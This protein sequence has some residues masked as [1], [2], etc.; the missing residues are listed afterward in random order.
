MKYFVIGDLQAK[1]ENLHHVESVCLEAETQEHEYVI[2]L[3]DMLEHRGRIEAEVLNFLY[4]YFKRSRK[5][6]FILC[7]NH[8]LVSVH[9]E[10]TALEPLKALKNVWVIDTPTFLPNP[11]T[12]CI[13]VPYYR[14]P[15]KFLH[16]ISFPGIKAV[17]CHQGIKEFTMGSGY[18]EDEAV[19]MDDVKQF[20][21]VVAGHYH[22]PMER[23]NV[24]YLGSPFSHS[25]GESNERKRYGIFDSDSLQFTYVPSNFPAHTTIEIELPMQEPITATYFG[26]GEGR[27]LSQPTR[28]IVTG[29]EDQIKDFQNRDKV[30]DKFPGVKFIY[31]PRGGVNKAAISDKLTNSDKFATWAKDIKKLDEKVTKMGLDLLKS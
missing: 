19:S 24:V 31:R 27:S 7:G 5:R 3:G 13:F 14:D 1:R 2:W 25:F 30:P 23:G 21:L 29:S 16:A 4:S 18:T 9:S 8:D 17:F 6:H 20:Q 11:D 12:H 15:A 26:F 10:S 28:A 22:T